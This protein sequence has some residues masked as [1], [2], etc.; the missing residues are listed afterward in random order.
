MTRAKSNKSLGR[1][2][3]PHLH[4]KDIPMV[5]VNHTYKEIGM[6]PKDI[7]SGGTGLYYSADAIWIIGR[8]QE[9]EGTE[10]KGYHFVI[11][12]EKSRHV[13]EKS[14]IPI[15]VTFEGG[16]AKWSG[17]DGSRTRRWVSA[18]TKSRMV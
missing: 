13:R 3:T 8:R 10:V 12:I 16:I 4:L 1:L 18:Q 2:I 15:S 9:K 5:V 11:N 14:A 7:V 6:F 17:P